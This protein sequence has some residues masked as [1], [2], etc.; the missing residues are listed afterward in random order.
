MKSRTYIVA[1]DEVLKNT[2][3]TVTQLNAAGHDYVVIDVSTSKEARQSWV[4][5]GTIR[6][7]NHFIWALS[8]FVASDSDIF[9]FNAGDPSFDRV[10]EYTSKAEGILSED[11]NVWLLAPNCANDHFTND[12]VKIVDSKKEPGLYLATHTNGIWVFFSRELAT[13]MHN[14]LTWASKTGR[15]DFSGMVSGWGLDTVYCAMATYHNKKVYRDSSIL[16]SHPRGSSYNY[17]KANKEY[18]EIVGAYLDYVEISGQRKDLAS[19]ICQTIFDKVNK[20]Q[21][22]QLTVEDVYVNLAALLGDI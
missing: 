13:M 12:G 3:N 5:T 14:F 18:Y 20:K 21:N 2:E 17:D 19:K 22:L 8:D 6:Y 16:V 9:V 7:Y 10:G 11:P 15:L 4:K 1:W